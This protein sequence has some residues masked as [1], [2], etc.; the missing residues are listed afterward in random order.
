MSNGLPR[1]HAHSAPV[2]AATAMRSQ[3]MSPA[4]T[5]AG[6]AAKSIASQGRRRCTPARNHAASRPNGASSTA[7]TRKYLVASSATPG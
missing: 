7:V 3:L 4:S 2:T 6:E 1:D 5:S